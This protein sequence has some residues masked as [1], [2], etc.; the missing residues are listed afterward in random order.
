MKKLKEALVL[1]LL[2]SFCSPH[3]FAQDQAQQPI[4]LTVL[5]VNDLHGHILPYIDK[6]ISEEI[7]VSGAAYLAK[8]IEA[9]RIVNPDGNLLLSAGD[10]FQGTPISNLFHGQSIMDIMNHL[11]FDAM[12][13]GNHEFDWGREILD[14]LRSSASFPFLSSNIVDKQGGILAGAKP[15]TLL[16]RKN[17]KI[18]VIGITTPETA[19]GT[20]PANVSD[21]TFLDPVT[22]LPGVI[23]E[24]KSLGADLVLV[25]S[26]LGLDEDKSLARNVSG[27][28]IIVGGHSHTAV[29]DP[30]KIDR[31]IIVQA[32][33]YGLYLGVL[34]LDVDP[35]TRRIIDYTSANEL[36]P[37]FA[38]PE[39]PFDEKT[40]SIV[41]AYN[42][43]IK[44]EFAR[45]VGETSVDL[46]RNPT[47]E[48]NIGNLIADA[49]KEATKA[50]VAFQ[51]G[52]GIRADMAAGKITME[53]VFTML[54]FDNALVVMDLSGGQILQ[55][56]EQN[57]T[58]D[59]KILQVSGL[60][61][62]YDLSAPDEAERVKASVDGK[63]IDP[64]KSYR[65]V[66]ND[67]L[68]AGG[69]R[70]SAFQQGANVVYDETV[71]DAFIAY[72]QKRSPVSPGIEDR[73]RFIK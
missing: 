32:G 10:M 1:V 34:Q 58:T 48:S 35:S 40:A 49:M 71:R 55:I 23:R 62:Q 21:L 64:G 3:L 73:I 65:V 7:P 19:Y 61:V 68:A 4:H 2:L 59:R 72:L 14:K 29:I 44:A 22:I 33:C 57:S 25:L 42:D 37:V 66:T 53:E 30:V 47:E 8:M 11:R 13:I 9:K 67:F 15:Y 16:T 63:P 24:V 6:S 69:D 28:D 36:K 41:A 46:M 12:A 27:I 17:L 38:G 70:F 56:L 31:T 18:A 20:K 50:D 45:V 26:H 52:G 54:P 5:H 43:Q 60:K 39:S 51:N